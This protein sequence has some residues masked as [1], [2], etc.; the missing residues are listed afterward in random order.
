MMIMVWPSPMNHS[1]CQHIPSIGAK[2]YKHSVDINLR[3]P[4]LP[5]SCRPGHWGFPNMPTAYFL[6]V[7]SLLMPQRLCAMSK[8]L[9]PPPGH[10]TE[11]SNSWLWTHQGDQSCPVSPQTHLS[12]S[13]MSTSRDKDSSSLFSWDKDMNRCIP[14]CPFVGNNWLQLSGLGGGT[15]RGPGGNE[16]VS[17]L[18]GAVLPCHPGTGLQSPWVLICTLGRARGLS[19]SSNGHWQSHQ[20][21]G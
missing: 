18:V 15:G 21:M 11:V 12:C 13:L 16:G 19:G 2:C 5:Q 4:F 14:L 17:S 3:V 6:I 1:S 7:H 20:G 9:C 8:A 10:Q